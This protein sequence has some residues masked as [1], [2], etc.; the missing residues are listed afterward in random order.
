M[1]DGNLTAYFELTAIIVV[2]VIALIVLY[3]LWLKSL[4]DSR[5]LF[6]SDEFHRKMIAWPM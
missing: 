2:V 4:R 3:H 5:P 6:V 1:F